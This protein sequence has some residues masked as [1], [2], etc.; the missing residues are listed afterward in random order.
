MGILKEIKAVGSYRKGKATGRKR[1]QPT[2]PDHDKFVEETKK[3]EKKSGRKDAS[4]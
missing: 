3:L 2:D 1:A 4:K